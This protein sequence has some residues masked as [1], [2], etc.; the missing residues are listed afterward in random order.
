MNARIIQSLIAVITLIVPNFM[1]AH[2]THRSKSV[3]TG[4]YETEM[5][6][7]KKAVRLASTLT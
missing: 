7:D 3:D 6:D 5:A 2:G 4:N 1:T